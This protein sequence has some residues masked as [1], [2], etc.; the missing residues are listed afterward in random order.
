MK[1]NNNKNH[2]CNNVN[3]LIND[4]SNWNWTQFTP[5]NDKKKRE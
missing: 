2:M 5:I 4:W 3:K 1:K